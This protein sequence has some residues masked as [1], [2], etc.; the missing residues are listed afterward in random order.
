MLFTRK[1]QCAHIGSMSRIGLFAFQADRQ[2]AIDN[3]LK[4]GVPRTDNYG[5]TVG[6]VIATQ[7]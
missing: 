6:L 3:S 5:F 4:S 7:R 2:G 1:G